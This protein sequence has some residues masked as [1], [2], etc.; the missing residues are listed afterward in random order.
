MS[1]KSYVDS[2][3][4]PHNPIIRIEIDGYTYSH[5]VRDIPADSY[6][7]LV[8]VLE[9]Q[10]QEVHDRAVLKTR[11]EIQVGIKDLLGIKG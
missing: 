10:M 5:N 2:R 3:S 4:D 1:R 8:S 7:W 9:D 11:K 6:E